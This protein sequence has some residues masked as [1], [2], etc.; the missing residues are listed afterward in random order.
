MPDEKSIEIGASES[1]GGPG[2]LDLE[3]IVYESRGCACCNDPDVTTAWRLSI[4]YRGPEPGSQIGYR[5]NVSIAL[6]DPC[7][8]ELGGAIETVR[9]A[10]PRR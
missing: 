9:A 10:D 8:E 6:C 5:S 7:L 2:G 4:G 3:P 1:L